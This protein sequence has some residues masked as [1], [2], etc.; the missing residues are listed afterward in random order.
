MELSSTSIRAHIIT[1]GCAK[2]EVDSAK[3]TERLLQAGVSIV[4]DPASADAI[5][6]NTCSFIQ[7]A[8][9]ESLEMIFDMLDMQNV[10]DG[11]SRVI[12]AGC[13]PARYGDDLASSLEEVDTF[14]PCSKEDDIAAIVLALFPEKA[15]H[16]M[17][18]PDVSK[19]I[20]A[21]SPSA[22]VKISDGCDRFCSFC[23]I[24]YIRGP[25]GSY[26]YEDIRNEVAAQIDRGVREIVLIA[27]DTGRWGEEFAEGQTLAWLLASLAEEFTDTWFRVMYL[28]PEGVTD[29]LIACIRDH[30]NVCSYLDIPFQHVDP[31]ILKSMNRRGSYEEFTALIDKIRESI[32]DI[33]L[34]TTLIAGFPG[35]TEA[36]FEYLCDFLE[37]VELDYVG[38]FPYSQEDGTRAAELPGQLEEQEKLE[39]AQMIRDLCDRISESIVRGRVGEEMDVLVLGAEEDGQVYGRAQCQAPEVDGVV[40]LNDGEPGEVVRVEIRDSLMYEMEG[41]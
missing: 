30:E 24:P 40:Y 28:E 25:Y 20:A 5:I 8:T 18:I 21:D 4:D 10:A 6:V 38:V 39:R 11:D 31:A 3:M 34:R 1:M 19:L 37:E 35:E 23:A 26:S 22:Y 29:E 15:S 7:A 33:V 2:N 12:V 16:C 14:V 32:P 13:M 41:W 36:Q 17:P 9:E 27:Q